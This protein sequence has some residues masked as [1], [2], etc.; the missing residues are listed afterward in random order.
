VL[1]GH[2]NI[3]DKSYFSDENLE[4]I[5]VDATHADFGPGLGEVGN[6]PDGEGAPVV[7]R[8]VQA[9]GRESESEGSLSDDS[10][11]SEPEGDET[12]D[13]DE[14]AA[15]DQEEDSSSDDEAE[16]AEGSDESEE[17]EEDE[18]WSSRYEHLRL[19]LNEALR[20]RDELIRANPPQDPEPVRVDPQRLAVLAQQDPWQAFDYSLEQ[21][22]TD[23]A[24]LVVADVAATAQDLF[25]RAH[26]ARSEGDEDVADQLHEAARVRVRVAEEMRRDA[27]QYEQQV[28][29]A[30]VA[31]KSFDE[32]FKASAAKVFKAKGGGEYAG[33]VGQ[34]LRDNPHF[35]QGGSLESG[36]AHALSVARDEDLDNVVNRRVKA[37]KETQRRRIAKGRAAG[38]ELS[39]G[40]AAAKP[41]KV[42]EEDQIRQSVLGRR[43]GVD[44]L[45]AIGR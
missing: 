26:V 9:S 44:A 32:E 25:A 14:E 2:H 30:P 41:V 42:S 34:I 10:G 19:R 37:A 21:G 7:E 45:W 1:A 17:P 4:A 43:T 20:E 31:Q 18:S 38:G 40:R 24:T 3:N 15:E 39:P 33:R 28:A 6:A 22:D 27:F 16:D 29:L 12:Q 5:G 11:S 23:S 13:P 8:D 36:I 35:L